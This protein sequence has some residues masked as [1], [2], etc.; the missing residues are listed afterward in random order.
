MDDLTHTLNR[1]MVFSKLDL[2]SGYHWL[3]LAEESRYITTF[4]MHK[5]LKRYTR[6]NFSINSASEIFQKVISEQIRNLQGALNISDDVIIFGKTQAEHDAALQAVFKRFS[7]VN[8]T[9]N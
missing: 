4:T 6:L 9:L 1:A 8:I 5:G 3:S 2:R 7:E